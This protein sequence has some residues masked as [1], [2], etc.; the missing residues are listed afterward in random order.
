MQWLDL[1]LVRQARWVHQSHTDDAGKPTKREN[2]QVDGRLREERRRNHSTMIFL[3]AT[4]SADTAPTLDGEHGN[5]ETCYD[6][7]AGA[8]AGYQ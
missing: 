5:M 8:T 4:D 6:N 2:D 3:M 7:Q 1:C